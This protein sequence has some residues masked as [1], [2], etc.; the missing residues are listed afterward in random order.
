[1]VP[2]RSRA[3]VAPVLIAPDPGA[4]PGRGFDLPGAMIATLGVSLLV[5]AWSAARRRLAVDRGLGALAAGIVLVLAFYAI[6]RE[7]GQG[8]A[9]RRPR[10]C[11]T[12]SLVTAMAVAFLHQLRAELRLLPVHRL[13]AEHP[14]LQRA[15]GRPAFLPLGVLAMVA[16]WQGSRPRCSTAARTHHAG[17][18]M[19]RLRDRLAALVSGIRSAVLRA[20]LP[21]LAL[22]GFG[23]ASAFTH[24]VRGAPPESRP[25]SKGSA[26][27]LAVDGPADGRLGRL[28]LILLIANSSN[29]V[30]NGAA[31]G[32]R[33]AA[34]GTLLGQ[35]RS[36]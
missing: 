1:V 27:A 17:H 33:V 32:G 8:S 24:G 20:V 25:W 31:H 36:P 15:A 22:Y 4:H 11:A 23:G 10:C 16:C 26:S 30:I 21:G 6:E 12:A 34:A 14:G 13:P 19:V 5:S 29:T 2:L 35:A 7:D 18:R 9:W 3:A 28:A